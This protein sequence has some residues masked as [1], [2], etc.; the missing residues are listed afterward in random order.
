MHLII[1]SVVTNEMSNFNYAIISSCHIYVVPPFKKK[2]KCGPK[3][4]H[5]VAGTPTLTYIMYCPYQLN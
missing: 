1:M 3:K 5:V 4:F 2:K